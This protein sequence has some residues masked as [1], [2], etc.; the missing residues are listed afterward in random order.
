MALEWQIDLCNRTDKDC[1]VTIHHTST[2]Q[3]WRRTAELVKATLKPSLRLYVEWSNEVW[4]SGFPVHMYADNAARQLDLPGENR[5][6][7]YQVYASVRM[8]EEFSRVFAGQDSRLVKVLAGQ[9]AWTGPCEAQA[10]A[11]LDAKVNPG[12]IRPD[13]YAIAPYFSGES[14]DELRRSI[15]EVRKWTEG[16]VKCARRIGVPLISYEGGSDSFSLRDGCARLQQDAAM[17]RLYVEYLES[18]AAAGLRGPFMQYTHS[19][20][21]WGAQAENRRSAGNLAQVPG[22]AG[23]AAESNS[24]EFTL[25]AQVADALLTAGGHVSSGCPEETD[26][27]APVT[28]VPAGDRS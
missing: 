6:A 3:D 11:L 14:V 2:A 19:G 1:W 18:Q 12:R 9:A 26:M 5:A 27:L 28:Q 13:V 20:G 24:D 21:C 17:R 4:N 16:S 23:L 15:D 8:F 7:V 10:S 22:I 25:D